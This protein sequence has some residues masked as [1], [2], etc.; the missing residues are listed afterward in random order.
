MG[1]VANGHTSAIHLTGSTDGNSVG[2]RAAHGLCPISQNDGIAG[3][4]PIGC[5]GPHDDIIGSPGGRSPRTDDRIAFSGAGG[6]RSAV[7]DHH[8]RN[9]LRLCPIPQRY[10]IFSGCL[11]KW[12]YSYGI[13]SLSCIPLISRYGSVTY[14]YTF[15]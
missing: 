9:T 7:T 11:G 13:H 8:G 10:G 3:I 14:S 12:T 5:L 6:C 2:R 1:A 15:G 4:C